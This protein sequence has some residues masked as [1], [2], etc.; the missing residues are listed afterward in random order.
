MAITETIEESVIGSST[1]VK[2]S[3]VFLLG[4]MLL[5]GF[6][7]GI[8]ND[9]PK[10]V[11]VTLTE[12]PSDG[13]TIILGAHTFEF[14]DTGAVAPGDIPVKIGSTLIETKANFEAAV[15]SNTDFS[16]E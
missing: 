1:L 8:Q 15:Q 6:A 13:D 3:A 4:L 11:T 5:G 7:A 12:I 10:S 9:N 16:A 14:V 2:A